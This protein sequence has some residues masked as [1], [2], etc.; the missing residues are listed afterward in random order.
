M[1][2]PLQHHLAYLCKIAM[3]NVKNTKLS[4]KN[5]VDEL[6][7]M[8]GNTGSL[9]GTLFEYYIQKEI[10]LV[11][12][13]FVPQIQ[14]YDRD[15]ICP[16][17][18]DLDFEIKT[19]SSNSNYVFGNRI[20]PKSINKRGGHY[21]LA[22]KYDMPTLNIKQIRFGW[23]D[24]DQWIQQKGNGQQSRLPLHVLRACSM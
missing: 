3:N 19:S 12:N 20:S 2:H 16:R 22:V 4:N 14:K 9:I 24:N 13:S 11:D 17:D 8:G 6:L 10:H 21:I 1:E 18:R 5:L 23:C 15:V 7:L